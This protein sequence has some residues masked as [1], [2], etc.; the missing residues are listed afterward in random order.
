MFVRFLAAEYGLAGNTNL[1]RAQANEVVDAVADLQ[2][3]MIKVAFGGD[4]KGVD[5]VLDN[6][7]PAGLVRNTPIIILS[8]YNGLSRLTLRKCWLGEEGSSLLVII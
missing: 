3:A 5:N 1:E 4:E 2:N 7:Y 6:V 8:V